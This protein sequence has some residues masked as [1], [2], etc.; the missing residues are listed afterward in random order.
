MLFA[1]HGIE[2]GFDKTQLSAVEITLCAENP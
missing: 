2:N 1:A